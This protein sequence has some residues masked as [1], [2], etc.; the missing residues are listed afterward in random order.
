MELTDAIKEAYAYADPSVTLFNTFEISHSTW[1]SGDYIRL[2]DS[3]VDLTTNQ[4]TFSPAKI[5]ASLPETESGVQG[6][7]QLKIDALPE[8]NKAALYKASRHTDPIYITFRQYTAANSDPQATLP[9]ALSVSTMEFDD[10]GGID[11][12]CLYPALVNIP[13]CRRIMTTAALPGGKV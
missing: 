4:G 13:F 6:K 10:K 1:L 2:V 3:D 9:V 11:I 12:T 5:D 7:M 8:E